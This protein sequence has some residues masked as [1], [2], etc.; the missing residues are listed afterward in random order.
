[1][2]KQGAD[3]LTASVIKGKGMMPPKGSNGQR[4]SVKLVSL[5]P[6]GMGL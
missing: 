6:L 2:L 3:A 1:L 5:L 4:L